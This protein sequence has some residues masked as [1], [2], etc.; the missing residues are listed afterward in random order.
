M[1]SKQFPFDDAEQREHHREGWVNIATWFEKQDGARATPILL[2]G[3]PKRFADQIMRWAQEEKR[4]ASVAPPIQP[5][6][7]KPL[8]QMGAEILGFLQEGDRSLDVLKKELAEARSRAIIGSQFSDL[9]SRHLVHLVADGF[10]TMRR[11]NQEI[12]ISLAEEA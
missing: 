12:I 1:H 2:L 9:V 8:T 3:M 11:R 5:R 6:P 7:V 4:K 10:I